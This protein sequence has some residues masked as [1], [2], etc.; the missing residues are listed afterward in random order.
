MKPI[1]LIMFQLAN[2]SKCFPSNLH[3]DENQ[4]GHEVYHLAENNIWLIYFCKV[5]SKDWVFVPLLQSSCLENPM[6]G[7][8]W[9][10]A[11]HGVAQSRTR[12][13][14]LS[15]S[16][17]THTHTHTHTNS[18]IEFLIPNVVVIRRW[19]LWEIIRSWG[20]ILHELDLCP[21][22]RDLREHSYPLSPMENTISQFS[23]T[24]SHLDLISGLQN[25]QIS[26][27]K[28]HLVYGTW[29]QHPNMTN[30]MVCCCCC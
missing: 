2:P 7:G 3:L 24:Q 20:W 19:S 10:A 18:H 21:N 15:S 14:W 6:D 29:L 8:T 17:H 4:S 9:V 23:E 25:W 16:S 28:I 27:F 13:K 1:M 11:V 5:V 30:S 26:V 22:T 12:L